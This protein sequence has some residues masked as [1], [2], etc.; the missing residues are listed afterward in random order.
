[1]YFT[2]YEFIL[3]IILLFILYYIIPKKFQWMLLLLGSYVFYS[4]AGLGYLAYI[5]VT[6]LSTYFVSRRL[7]FLQIRGAN[8]IKENKAEMTREERKAYKAQ[9]KKRQRIW[10]SK[11]YN[12][13]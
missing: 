2:S 11:F 13:R 12:E 7:G 9:M 4:F 3:F 10:L 8:Y 1:M 6:T 5:A